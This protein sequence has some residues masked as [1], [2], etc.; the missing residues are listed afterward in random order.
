MNEVIHGQPE[1]LKHFLFRTALLKRFNLPLA[2]EITG[3]ENAGDMIEELNRKNLFLITLDS[4]QG[5]YRYHNI[6]LEAMT[7]GAGFPGPETC[8]AIHRRAAL[9][10]ARNGHY[11]D[12]FEHAFNSRDLE[13]T[14]DLMEDHLPNL[15]SLG[16]SAASLR[17]L[18][19]LPDEILLN[20]PLLRL[21]ECG[22]KLEAMNT[23]GIDGLLQEF[24]RKGDKVFNR[25]DPDKRAFCRDF[26]LYLKQAHR[27]ILDPGGTNNLAAQDPCEYIHTGNSTLLAGTKLLIGLNNLYRGRPADAEKDIQEAA[28][29]IFASENHQAGIACRRCLSMLARNQGRLHEAEKILEDGFEFLDQKGMGRLP[30]KLLLYFPMAE[31]Y[32]ERNDLQKALEYLL[33]SRKFAEHARYY[34]DLLQCYYLLSGI[35]LSGGEPEKAVSFRQKIQAISETMDIP[36]IRGLAQ[37]HVSLLA[38]RQGEPDL[39]GKWA[40]KRRFDPDEPFSLL[41]GVEGMAQANWMFFNGEFEKSLLQSIAERRKRLPEGSYI[42]TL[43][44][45]CSDNGTGNTASSGENRIK[46]DCVVTQREIEILRLMA[47]EYK[48]LEIAGKAFISLHTVKTH[49]KNI[50]KKLDVPSRLKAVSRAR[51]LGLFE[52]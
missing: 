43:I 51:E 20:R 42:K 38:L 28:A 7:D 2:E 50:Y 21:F 3:M 32:Y 48:D 27:M 37:A 9:W 24:E 35:Y 46:R 22:F 31:I 12:A 44:R 15:Y 13:F 11:E 4:R 1:H 10:F 52:S 34:A 8:A 30:L 49:A 45:H 25:Y 19:K 14:A 26:F 47:A 40:E 29:I 33:I 39:A 6:F 17:W 16:E 18:Y 41:Y 5:W 23:W 36:M